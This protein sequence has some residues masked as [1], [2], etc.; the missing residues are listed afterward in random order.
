MRGRQ[1]AESG[2]GRLDETVEDLRASLVRSGERLTVNA[3]DLAIT[4]KLVGGDAHGA[5]SLAARTFGPAVGRLCFLLLGAQGEA[6]EAAQET[7]LAAYHGAPTYRAEGSVRSWLFGIA[8]RI[9]AQRLATRAR[10]ARRLA[11]L[12]VP[13]EGPTDA[14]DLHDSAERE[15]EVRAALADLPGTDRELLALRYD[16]EHSF[17]EIADALGIDEAA[18]RK[19]VGRA[20]V[21]LRER[22]RAR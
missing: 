9:C 18:A 6:D 10:Q 15:A 12:V 16:A 2:A 8:R 19:R 20:L 7:F 22:V 1:T 11:L 13:G 21:R 14:S 17:R 3:E 5:I 4:A